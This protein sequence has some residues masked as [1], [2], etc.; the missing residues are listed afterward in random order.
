MAIT[1][2]KTV[3]ETKKINQSEK[4]SFEGGH[5]LYVEGNRSL[6][7]FSAV[8]LTQSIEESPREGQIVTRVLNRGG[9]KN[10][11]TFGA[12]FRYQNKNNFYAIDSRAF[13]DNTAGRA[14]NDDDDRSSDIGLFKRS[15]N[16]SG[17]TVNEENVDK[18]NMEQTFTQEGGPEWGQF[19]CS[20]FLFDGELHFR[21]EYRPT[22][23]AEWARY[24]EQKD[25]VDTDP[26]LSQ[27]GGIGLTFSNLSG[28]TS[29]KEG[30]R[31][32]R[33]PINFD[34]T[35]ILYSE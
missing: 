23:D 22:S 17:T 28:A 32:T 34:S 8:V 13:A 27:G 1:D 5:S 14:D 4:H 24:N 26:D 30:R 15:S 29:K 18:I 12:V 2:W 20:M 3:G 6:S 35:T 9:P 25:L 16:D 19:R 31:D 21:P 33:G 11:N 10:L 7:T